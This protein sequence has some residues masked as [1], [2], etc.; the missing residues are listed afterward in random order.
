MTN[1]LLM[2]LWI[3]WALLLFG[4]LLFGH[5]NDAGSG[6]M[7][8]WTR[9][10]SSFVLVVA[11][12]AMVLLTPPAV[13]TILTYA[14]VVSMGM[15]LGFI[16][17]LAIAGL[18]RLKQPVIGGIIGFGLGHMA[19]ISAIWW[20]EGQF[21]YTDPGIRIGSLLFWFFFGTVSWYIAVYRGGRG[22]PLIWAALPYALLLSGTVGSA[23]SLAVQAHLFIPLVVGTA[24]FLLSDL[25]LAAQLFSG[26][27]FRLIND[28]IWLTYGP[29]QMLIVYS[30]TVVWVPASVR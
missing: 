20:L 1:L 16:G 11:A 5:P 2:V 3:G 8:R 17:D 30:I 25:I 15:L 4:G 22:N 23:T 29:A 26:A 13:N 27:R 6:R 9:L 14:V 7:P 24:L 19:Y 21:G 28:V 12:W 18:L 10:A